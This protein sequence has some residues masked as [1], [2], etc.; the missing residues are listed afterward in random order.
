MRWRTQ[1]CRIA[2]DAE[3]EP[4]RLGIEARPDLIKP[5]RHE[6]ALLAGRALDSEAD[7]LAAA[8]AIVSGGVDAALVSMDTDGSVLVT[9]D[10]VLAAQ[11]VA[12]PVHTTVGAGDAMLAGYLRACED[13]PEAAMRCAVAAATARVAGEDGAIERYMPLVLMTENDK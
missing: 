10:G 9:A 3:G 2:L 6:L 7:V 12:V 5:N 1:G 11:A 8:G 13:R 4:L